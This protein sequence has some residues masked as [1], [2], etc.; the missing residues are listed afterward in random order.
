MTPDQILDRLAAASL[1]WEV[2]AN[3]LL[4][5]TL[6]LAAGLCAGRL[7][8]SCGAAVQSLVY[9]TTLVAVLLC[10]LLALGLTVAGFDRLVFDIE[11]YFRAEARDPQIALK[12]TATRETVKSSS[13]DLSLPPKVEA[14]A[15][16]AAAQPEQTASLSKP[17]ISHVELSAHP[18]YEQSPLAPPPPL[19]KASQEV[20]PSGADAAVAV[21]LL[22]AAMWLVA[23]VYLLVRLAIAQL[24]TVWLRRMAIPVD[25]AEIA[26]CRQLA[27]DIRLRPPEVL[28]APFLSSACLVGYWRPAVLLPDA[29]DTQLRQALVHELAHLSPCSRWCGCWPGELR[30]RLKR[31]ATISSCSTAP[32]VAATRSCLWNWPAVTWRRHCRRAWA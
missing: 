7:S 4:Q 29:D 27:A 30:R 3:V 22:I 13:F 16:P 31:C 18:R 24:R 11:P 14:D 32:T 8:R 10:P 6:I 26:L 9:R 23:S 1:P 25:P 20:E 28:R 5:T 19:D 17:Q 21:A 12:S 15:K 2:A